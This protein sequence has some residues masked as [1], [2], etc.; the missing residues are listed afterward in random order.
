MA[1]YREWAGGQGGAAVFDVVHNPTARPFQALWRSQGHSSP[2]DAL[3]ALVAHLWKAGDARVIRAESPGG[4][5]QSPG[6]EALRCQWCGEE[7]HG[8]R[9]VDSLRWVDAREVA[10]C[11]ANPHGALHEPEEG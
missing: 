1:E 2:E 6:P 7:I 9:W 8:A 10:L 4:S 11:P 3:D 5:D